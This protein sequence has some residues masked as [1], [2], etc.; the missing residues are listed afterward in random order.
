MEKE[1]LQKQIEIRFAEAKARYVNSIIKNAYTDS[2]TI[3][4]I[5]DKIK[6][7]LEILE[8]YL[9]Q[10]Y[11]EEL[12]GVGDEYEI[13]N[14]ELKLAESEL[15]LIKIELELFDKCIDLDWSLNRQ[16]KLISRFLAEDALRL[17]EAEVR[18]TETELRLAE[19]HVSNIELDMFYD[20]YNEAAKY[21]NDH[22]M[23]LGSLEMYELEEVVIP[24]PEKYYEM[25][26]LS[27]YYYMKGSADMKIAVTS[28]EIHI[29]KLRVR[30]A[31]EELCVANSKLILAELE[32]Y[33][34]KSKK[35]DRVS[36]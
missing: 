27:D 15:E 2:E 32:R 33:R 31:K 4:Y 20:P 23:W 36:S 16:D 14:A 28:T 26:E 3:L 8:G 19:N 10:E 9:T 34:I 5:Q 25:A 18:L 30:L 6:S 11:V 1:I 13:M 24:D 12:I 7:G 35:P 17:S 29:A 22:V 21:I